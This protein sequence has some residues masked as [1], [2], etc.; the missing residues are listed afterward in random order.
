M[1]QNEDIYTFRDWL[2]DERTQVLP[3]VQ[4]EQ[5]IGVGKIWDGMVSTPSVPYH[6][7][8]W[9]RPLRSHTTMGWY[10]II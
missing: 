4:N 10:G 6:G 5:S 8:G 1:V 3:E 9:Y 7:M 2:K